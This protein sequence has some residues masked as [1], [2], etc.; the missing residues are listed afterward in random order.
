MK[1]PEDFASLTQKTQL[2]ANAIVNRMLAYSPSRDAHERA[3]LVQ[4]KQIDRLS[5]LLCGVIDLA[6]LIRN[7]DPDSEWVAH[8]DAAYQELCYYM[9]QLN[10]HVGLYEVRLFPG[11]NGHL[12]WASFCTR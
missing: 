2:R 4:V 10:T 6:E 11:G 7:V 12:L 1:R 8:A 9:N 3:L 5:D